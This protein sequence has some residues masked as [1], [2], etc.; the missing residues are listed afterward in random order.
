MHAWPEGVEDAS[1]THLYARLTLV[2]I[3]EQIRDKMKPSKQTRSKTRKQVRRRREKRAEG[4]D[5][6]M[7]ADKVDF[8][9][10]K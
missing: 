1:H 6:V 10:D 3:P 7:V 9:Y 5:G 8:N 2:G 4:R